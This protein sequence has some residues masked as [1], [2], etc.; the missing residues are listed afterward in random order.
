MSDFKLAL[1]IFQGALFVLAVHIVLSWLES[2]M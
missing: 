2:M 1:V